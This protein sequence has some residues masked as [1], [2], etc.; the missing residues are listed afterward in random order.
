MK[1]PTWRP[2]IWVRSRRFAGGLVGLAVGDPRLT[3]LHAVQSRRFR[4]ALVAVGLAIICGWLPGSASAPRARAQDVVRLGNLKFVH[5]GAVSY[6]KEIAGRRGL[7]IEE[8]MFAK[9]ADIMPAVVAGQIDVAASAADAA[10]SARANGVPI[11]VVAGFARGGARIMAGVEIGVRGIGDLKGKRVGVTRGGAHELLLLAV[12]DRAGLTWSEKPGK[13][14]RIVYLGYPDLNQALAA[15]QIDAM[16]QSEPQAAQ[17]LSKKMGVE[18]SRPYDTPMGEP[19]RTLVMTEALL[20]KRPDV[21][22][23]L[24]SLFVEATQAFKSDPKL[25]ER[26]VRETLFKGHLDAADYK[27]ALENAAFTFDVTK[28]HIAITTEF[29]QKYGV[30]RMAR[31][32]KVDDWV[33]LELLN[34]AKA[35]LKIP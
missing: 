26:Y 20:A 27:A 35:Q 28:E 7:K 19:V 15:K 11:V 21:A 31:P 3:R 29:M 30:G 14:V 10:I 8:R 9:G 2:A 6:M 24:V 12:L 4:V 1:R 18:I 13:D 17:A 25:A 16:C 5:Y 32:P 34:A 22:R 33:K 23:R